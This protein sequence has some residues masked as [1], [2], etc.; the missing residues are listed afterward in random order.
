MKRTAL[1][2]LLCLAAVLMLVA[3]ACVPQGE[4]PTE[5]TRNEPVANLK[6]IILGTP[7]A[8]GMDEL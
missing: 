6:A 3:S 5:G 2:K 4:N 8:E 1:S 7:P